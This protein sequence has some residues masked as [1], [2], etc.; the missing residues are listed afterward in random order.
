NC[1]AIVAS[2]K[3][4][5][6]VNDA[7]REVR[8]SRALFCKTPIICWTSS[9]QPFCRAG[10]IPP[11]RGAARSPAL[12]VVGEGIAA[13]QHIGYLPQDVELFA[14]TVAQNIARFEPETDAEAVL[15]AA[16]AADVHDLILR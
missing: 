10:S 6:V 11:S 2:I 14:G 12:L 7:D 13:G 4:F 8:S 15:E 5:K 1:Q 9:I 16:K 3:N